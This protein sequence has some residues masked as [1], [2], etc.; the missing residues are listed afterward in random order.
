[1]RPISI[2]FKCFGPYMQEQF[3]DFRELEQSGLFLICGETGSGK[4][5]ILDAMCYALYGKSSGGFRGKLSDMRCKKAGPSD[6]T[7]VEYIFSSGEETYRFYREIKPRKQQK[8]KAGKPLHFNEDYACQILKDGQFVPL[9]DTKATQ[10]YI[11][12]KAEEILG[13]QYD[14]FKQVIILPQGQFEKLLT[15]NSDEKEEILV[16]L[17]HAEKWKKIADH[18]NQQVTDQKKE[19][20]LKK[21]AMEQQMRQFHCQNL[22]ELRTLTA[23]TEQEAEALQGQYDAL[24][25]LVTDCKK[26]LEQAKE[27]D[28][29]FAELECAEKALRALTQQKPAQEDHQK[30]LQH[31]QA[32]E[33]ITPVFKEKQAAIQAVE[34]AEQERTAQENALRAAEIQVEAL[35]KEQADHDRKRKDYEENQKRKILLENLK[36]LYRSLDSRKAACDDAETAFQSAQTA[37][38]AAQEKLE[39]AKETLDQAVLAQ[40]RT[41]QAYKE[42]QTIYLREIGSTLAAGLKEGE[43]CPVCGSCHH[44]EPAKPTEDHISEAELSRRRK[45]SQAAMDIVEAATKARETANA[46]RQQAELAQTTCFQNLESAKG[47]YEEALSQRVEQIET[48]KQRQSAV[49][50]LSAAIET[51]EEADHTMQSRMTAAMS[52][53]QTADQMAQT[54]KKNA[55]TAAAALHQAEKAW[56][57]ALETANFADQ[58]QYMDACMEAEE[59][60]ALQAENIQFH[61]DL[62]HA[63]KDV[64]AKKDR[65]GDRVRPDV[66]GAKQA[67][68][69]AETRRD[70]VNE[71]H[72][73]K[74]KDLQEQKTVLQDLEKKLPQLEQAQLKN[75]ENLE[76]AQRI[77]GDS[78]ISLQRYV[79]GVMLTSITHAANQLL[80]TVYGGRYQLY[81]TNEASGKAHKRGLELEVADQDGRRNVNTLSGGEKFLLSL[82]LGIGL[83]TVVQ[84][85]GSGI[86]LEA[87]FIDE[88]FGSLDEK[89]ID[90]AME[91]LE[92]V[93]RSSGIVGIISHVERLAET[94]P[95]KIEI[96]KGRDGSQC[97]VCC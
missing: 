86:R 88:G 20:D 96:S 35:Q 36:D 15:S 46:E 40:N 7:F 26:K 93:R 8:A 10:K 83:A 18:I 30:R 39:S 47:R 59:R 28:K 84:A 43:R 72:I 73:C 68:S 91:I 38:H 9:S 37:F 90:D 31:A 63:E 57:T 75:R 80:K 62:S 25:A 22:E 79:L 24:D 89:S 92:S 19:L 54:A 51:F 23:Q 78:G 49:K 81:R 33:A 13:L 55:E 60:Q 12:H 94:I 56:E 58:E 53:R 82:S 74:K 17:F 16:T 34:K 29:G 85:Q 69:E 66:A 76:F 2:R 42:G 70:A 3:I 52:T 77:R 6:D 32:A 95:A 61:T 48:E 71:Q 11:D 67:L 27:D 44:P 1:M 41:D 97:R 87:M 65:L 5:T 14:Q 45:A 4:T 64:Q 50:K 21:A